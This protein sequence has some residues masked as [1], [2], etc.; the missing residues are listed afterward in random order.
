VIVDQRPAWAGIDPYNKRI[1][2]NSD[3]NLVKVEV[4]AAP[5]AR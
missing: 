4:R 5:P 2:R 1:D 3:D